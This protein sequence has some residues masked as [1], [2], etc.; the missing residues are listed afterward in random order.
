MKKLILIYLLSI[1]SFSFEKNLVNLIENRMYELK[2]I[3]YN[4]YESM[5]IADEQNNVYYKYD[6]TETRPLAS[7]TKLM[8]AIVVFEDINSGKYS[9]NSTVVATKASS[10]VP[11][12]YRVVTGTKYTVEDL[13]KLLL[14]NSSNSAAYLLAENSAGN[15]DYFVKK[16]NDKAKD[17]E[18]RSLRYYTPHGLPPV[19]SNRKMDIGNARDIYELAKVALKNKKILEISNNETVTISNGIKV[20]STNTLIG[21]Y[22]EVLGLKTGYHSRSMYNIVYYMDF[23][24][25]KV[26][27]VILGSKNIPFRENLGIETINIMRGIK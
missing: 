2:K 20:K 11:Y 25:E 10:S 7:V 16:M 8:T 3:N 22:K 4:Y 27:Q 5:Y 21:K 18:L 17:L 15:V 26:I 14:V 12:G 13:L 19:D 24:N 23:G 6:E 1:I 9:L